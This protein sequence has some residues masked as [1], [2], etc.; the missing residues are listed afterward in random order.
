MERNIGLT[1]LRW[2]NPLEQSIWPLFSP[3]HFAIVAMTM[4]N[5]GVKVNHELA[6]VCHIAIFTSNDINLFFHVDFI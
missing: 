4:C 5:V 6:T 2:L 3:L 1:E